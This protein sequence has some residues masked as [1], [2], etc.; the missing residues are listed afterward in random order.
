MIIILVEGEWYTVRLD[1]EV[2]A[3]F[4][5]SVDAHRFAIAMLHDGLASSVALSNGVSVEP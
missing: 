3:W 5:H 2:L 4:A 1:G